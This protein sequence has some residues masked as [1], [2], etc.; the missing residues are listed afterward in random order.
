MAYK[1]ISFSFSF[2]LGKIWHVV[3]QAVPGLPFFKSNY[4]VAKI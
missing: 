3:V 4:S 1:I 2:P